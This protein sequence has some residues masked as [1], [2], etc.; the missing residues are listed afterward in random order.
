MR[1]TDNL[2]ENIIA[3]MEEWTTEEMKS[4]ACELIK[5]NHANNKEPQMPQIKYSA[6]ENIFRR[7]WIC[8]FIYIRLDEEKIEKKNSII[9]FLVP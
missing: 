5:S 3:T 2:F 8:T 6:D 1:D 9:I 7:P 4:Q